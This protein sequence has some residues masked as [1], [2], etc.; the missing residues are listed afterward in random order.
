MNLAN[1]TIQWIGKLAEIRDDATGRHIERVQEYLELLIKAAEEQTMGWDVEAVLTAAVLHDV[2]K[3][4]VPDS[5]L[6]KKGRLSL[7]E[8]KEMEKHCLYGKE[9]LE[10]L[11]KTIK[12]EHFL[13]YAKNIALYHH[14]KW[15]G[16]GY[17]ERLKGEEIPLEARMMALVDVYDALVS[18]RPYKAA[19]SHESAMEIILDGKGSHF[20][21]DLLDLFMGLTEE[22][23][24]IPR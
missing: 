3:I 23:K 15:D 12:Y 18:E 17:P 21:P 8:F 7:Q 11:Q 2:G 19:Y 13:V 1:A 5:I 10:E 20:D 9:L 24:A 16:T 4:K 14:E 6:L 22:I